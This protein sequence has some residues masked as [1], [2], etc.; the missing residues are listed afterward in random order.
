LADALVAFVGDTVGIE[1]ATLG[2][3]AAITNTSSAINI[4]LEVVLEPIY[5]RCCDTRNVARILLDIVA[6]VTFLGPLTEVVDEPV[7]TAGREAGARTVAVVVIFDSGIT[8][9][10]GNFL[11]K[12]IATNGLG[13]SRRTRICI[14]IVA[15]VASLA[16]VEDPIA[17]TRERTLC[18]TAIAILGIAIVATLART[19]DPVAA[20]R[21]E[22]VRFAC[23]CIVIV[24][25]VVTLLTWAK[26]A[27]ATGP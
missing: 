20:S 1:L 14:V 18:R 23:A 10:T 9:F 15:V 8:L 24:L 6:I 26:N 2:E 21:E 7:A 4:G 27:V 17:A 3:A 12:A 16:F 13:T 19:Q 25:A 5:T 11:D 22:A